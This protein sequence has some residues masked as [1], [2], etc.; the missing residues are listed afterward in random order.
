MW[1]HM[2]CTL[3]WSKG[4]SCTCEPQVT[5]ETQEVQCSQESEQT[6]ILTVEKQ[7][8]HLGNELV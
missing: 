8:L 5:V 3:T 2:Q 7:T 1:S 4:W 6:C